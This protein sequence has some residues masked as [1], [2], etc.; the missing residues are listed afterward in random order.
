M[1]DTAKLIRRCTDETGRI[2]KRM[3]HARGVSDSN[4]FGVDE[5]NPD[6]LGGTLPV[7]ARGFSVTGVLHGRP[8]WVAVFWRGELGDQVQIR[9]WD[10]E[11]VRDVLASYTGDSFSP[12]PDGWSLPASPRRPRHDSG[13]AVGA[14]RP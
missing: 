8:F 9:G 6:P 2:D 13:R 14:G 12:F 5:A 4:L 11:W 3:L 10:S 7:K 1:D